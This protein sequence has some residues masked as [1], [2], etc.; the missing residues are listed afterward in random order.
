VGRASS[1]GNP[2]A[3][4]SSMMFLAVAPRVAA[5]SAAHLPGLGGPVR[6]AER[7]RKCLTGT[8]GITLSSR[9][10]NTIQPAK[11]ARLAAQAPVE[12]VARPATG[13]LAHRHCRRL[14]QAVL[15]KERV[16]D[17]WTSWRA[18]GLANLHIVAGS[19]PVALTDPAQHALAQALD[20]A[21]G[22]VLVPSH[23]ST[24]DATALVTVS[25]LYI[26]RPGWSFCGARLLRFGTPMAHEPVHR[27]GF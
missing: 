6:V 1:G 15:P 12:P 9:G 24:R 22:R 8:S 13:S 10:S 18:P 5:A 27:H 21:T 3:V 7:S 20:T 2:V 14:R 16:F 19:C 4:R 23:P 17:G 25:G 11:L 26:A